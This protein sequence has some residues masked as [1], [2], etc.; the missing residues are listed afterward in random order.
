MRNYMGV[1][2]KKDSSSGVNPSVHHLYNYTL[3]NK[4]AKIKVVATDRF[5]NVYTE[6][7]ITD[8]TDYTYTK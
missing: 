3:K 8:G 1:L 7:K 2:D 4:N 5:G 6:T